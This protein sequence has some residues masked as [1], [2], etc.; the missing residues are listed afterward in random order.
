MRI[1]HGS[2]FVQTGRKRE[3]HPRLGSKS[4]APPTLHRQPFLPVQPIH[5]L[6]VDPPPKRSVLGLLPS[7]KNVQSPISES[8]ALG[9]PSLSRA[10]NTASFRSLRWY[11][12]LPRCI[13][14]SPQACRSLSPASSRTT[15]TASRSACGPTTFL[16]APP[17]A[18][19][20]PAPAG[21]RSSSADR[22]LP[23]AAAAASP[24]SLPGPHTSPSSGRTL[25]RSPPV[26]GTDPSP[27]PRPPPP[28]TPLRSALH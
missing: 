21:P 19:R 13:P 3:W 25:R 8:R 14:I 23:P 20:G 10:R 15:R 6:V 9:C 17:S 27:G 18:H 11:R 4:L 22:S 28:S 7:Q 1:V 12:Q 24:R 5:S 16:T 2:H 26:V